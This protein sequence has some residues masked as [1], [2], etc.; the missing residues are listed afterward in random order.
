MNWDDTKFY[1]KWEKKN[2]H[3]DAIIEEDVFFFLE[4]MKETLVKPSRWVYLWADEPRNNFISYHVHIQ[5][6]TKYEKKQQM[7]HSG[8]LLWA[9]CLRSAHGIRRIQYAI[10]KTI[11]QCS[12]EIAIK[13]IT[14]QKYHNL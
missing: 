1:T 13:L 4:K 2:N 6:Q 9:S 5:I 8:L 7:I 11:F 3:E 14:D 12:S 10:K